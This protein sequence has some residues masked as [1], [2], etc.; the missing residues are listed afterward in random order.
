MSI[1]VS[2]KIGRDEWRYRITNITPERQRDQVNCYSVVMGEPDA[3]WDTMNMVTHTP[4][5]GA[6]VLVALAVSA[7]PIPQPAAEPV[8]VDVAV[9]SET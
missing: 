6:S 7:M 8:T 5:D 1:H 2:V 3:D 4:N 9:R